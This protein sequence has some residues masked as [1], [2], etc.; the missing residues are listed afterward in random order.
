MG[1]C[2]P[3]LFSLPG[4]W[5]PC[6][7]TQLPGYAIHLRNLLPALLVLDGAEAPANP[8]QRAG[9]AETTASEAAAPLNTSVPVVVVCGPLAGCVSNVGCASFQAMGWRSKGVTPHRLRCPTHPHLSYVSNPHQE[10]AGFHGLFGPFLSPPVSCSPPAMETS[11]SMLCVG[12]AVR[13][14]GAPLGLAAP[15]GARRPPVALPATLPCRP[16]AARLPWQP[17]ASP[18]AVPVR[19]PGPGE[20]DR[21]AAPPEARQGSPAAE[22][23]GPMR[24]RSAFGHSLV[25]LHTGKLFIPKFNRPKKII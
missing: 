20:E 5:V 22:G 1:P 25:G 6:A 7:A 4:L 23:G 10:E 24:W 3:G 19:L 18:G 9:L 17:P 15:R 14:G 11:P 16:F 13:P 21:P 2:S 8:V 12:R